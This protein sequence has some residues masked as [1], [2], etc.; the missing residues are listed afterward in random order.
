[1][2]EAFSAKKKTFKEINRNERGSGLLRSFHTSL[3]QYKHRLRWQGKPS[4]WDDL[5]WTREY[6]GVGGLTNHYV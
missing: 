6:H 4:K 5:L 2:A 1:M 3:G